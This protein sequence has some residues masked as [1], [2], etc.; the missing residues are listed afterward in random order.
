MFKLSLANVDLIKILH[1]LLCMTFGKIYFLVIILVTN[2][3]VQWKNQT[4]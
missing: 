4:N 2:I 1:F 3:E